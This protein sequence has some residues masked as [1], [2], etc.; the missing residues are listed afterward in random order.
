M[1]RWRLEV[2]FQEARARLGI[3]TQRQWS[4]RAIART[5]PTLLG[6][7][8]WITLAAHLLGGRQLANP[9]SAA[10]YVKSE[11]TFVDAIALARRQLWIASETFCASPQ[12]PDMQ[13]IPTPLFNRFI[14]SLTYAA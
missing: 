6:L 13:Q 7:F 9:R 8:L 1:L 2:T 12:K 11:P 14:E 10:W 4:D 3:E 5:T